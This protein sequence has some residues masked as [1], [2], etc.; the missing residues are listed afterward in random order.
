MLGPAVGHCNDHFRKTLR[1]NW[2]CFTGKAEKENYRSDLGHQKH[3]WWKKTRDGHQLPACSL[4]TPHQAA[5]HLEEPQHPIRPN[6]WGGHNEGWENMPK[7]YG[8]V[9]TW[10]VRYYLICEISLAFYKWFFE[11]LHVSGISSCFITSS[12]WICASASQSFNCAKASSAT[13]L[14][15]LCATTFT[16]QPNFERSNNKLAKCTAASAESVP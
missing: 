13:R 5:S 16:V 2:P 9:E 11:L 15:R 12:G 1:R 7:I 3:I 6:T 4:E 14:P 8:D 10:M